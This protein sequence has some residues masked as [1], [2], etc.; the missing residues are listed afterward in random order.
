MQHSPLRLKNR[1][2]LGRLC[3]SPLPPFSARRRP[4]RRRP[5]KRSAGPRTWREGR[6][7]TYLADLSRADLRAAA[8][9]VCMPTPTCTPPQRA[10]R[11]ARRWGWG[12]ARCT[13][14]IARAGSCTLSIACLKQHRM[15]CPRAPLVVCCWG[16]RAVFSRYFVLGDGYGGLVPGRSDRVCL[17]GSIKSVS[18]YLWQMDPRTIGCSAD[19]R[20]RARSHTSTPLLVLL[21]PPA[22]WRRIQRLLDRALRV[23]MVG[24][25][26]TLRPL[27]IAHALLRMHCTCTAPP[28]RRYG[29]P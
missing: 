6:G 4:R 25:V 7:A 2:C 14:R 18:L 26:S 12:P 19:N 27:L 11:T 16:Q 17:F 9:H 22:A 20:R 1:T 29:R 21:L 23:G 28:A 5:G 3:P 13:G 15:L 24:A 10:E 8:I